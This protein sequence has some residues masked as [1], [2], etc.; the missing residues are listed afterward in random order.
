MPAALARMD[1]GY[2]VTIALKT[3]TNFCLSKASGS[4]IYSV[5]RGM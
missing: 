2:S 1:L 3:R 4:Y 5:D